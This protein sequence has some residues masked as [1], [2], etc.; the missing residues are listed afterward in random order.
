MQ[1]SIEIQ[2]S[3]FPNHFSQYRG[4]FRREG[5]A[6]SGSKCESPPLFDVQEARAGGTKGSITL[7]LA[8]RSIKIPNGIV[9]D[10]LI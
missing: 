2:R 7:S 8:D 10:V 5:T 9:E 3:R 6:G 4:H 1:D